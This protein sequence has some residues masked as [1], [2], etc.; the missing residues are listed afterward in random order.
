MVSSVSLKE[1]VKYSSA[2]KLPD[3]VIDDVLRIQSNAYNNAKRDGILYG[4]VFTQYSREEVIKILHE[5][6]GSLYVIGNPA[7][8][9]ALTMQSAR[10]KS[11]IKNCTWEISEAVNIDHHRYLEQI[12]IS[13]EHSGKSIGKRL[14]NRILEDEPSIIA[15][16]CIEPKLNNV[17]KQF[18]L[19]NGF[20]KIGTL[21]NLVYRS[22]KLSFEAVRTAPRQRAKGAD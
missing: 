6:D 19:K 17:A 11:Y 7:I 4:F 16:Y 8:G 13:D 10:L 21:N 15:D 18:F 2:S 20:Q 12:I 14:L 3:L 9:F 1:I 5:F 22:Q